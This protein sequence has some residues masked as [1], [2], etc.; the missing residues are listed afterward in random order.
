MLNVR[1]S[2]IVVGCVFV[3]FVAS[4]GPGLVARAAEPDRWVENAMAA[5]DDLLTA[6][7]SDAQ[8]RV[9]ELEQRVKELE[10]ERRVAPQAERA[11]GQAP[12][13]LTAAIARNQELMAR[14]RSLS[15]E[16]QELVQSQLFEH[17]AGVSACEPPPGDADPKAQLRYWADQLRTGDN[18]F[19]SRL[20]VEQNAALNVLLRRDRELDAQIAWHEQ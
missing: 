3:G 14:I 9:A 17:Q 10:A 5:G 2:L 20:T 11:S 4:A 16:N 12:R 18:G 7:G 8:R 1:S 6:D 13:E 15:I 19:R